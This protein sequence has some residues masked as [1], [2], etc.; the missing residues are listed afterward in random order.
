VSVAT[1]VH[2]RDAG[3]L[4][5]QCLSHGGNADSRLPPPLRTAR[6]FQHAILVEEA[7]DAIEVTGVECRDGFCERF[8]PRL[9]RHG[10]FPSLI[11]GRAQNRSSNST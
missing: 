3:E 11:A 6:H 9:I 5:A 8:D 4:P 10:A 1:I 2:I 7:H